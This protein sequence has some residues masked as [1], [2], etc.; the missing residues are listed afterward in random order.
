[1]T[2]TD[3]HEAQQFGASADNSLEDV[4]K[5]LRRLQEPPVESPVETPEKEEDY[6]T[7]SELEADFLDGDS[8]SGDENVPDDADPDSAAADSPAPDSPAPDGETRESTIRG[9][10]LELNERL[11]RLANRAEAGD[12]EARAELETIFDEHPRLWTALGDFGAL[13]EQQLID[14]V[15]QGNALVAAAARRHMKQMK[16]GL[17]GPDPSM[18]EQLA[19]QR[20][21]LCWLMALA[22]D[23]LG[24]GSDGPRQVQVEKKFEQA[25]KNFKLVRQI[26]ERHRR[27]RKSSRAA[28][29]T[30]AGAVRPP[31]AARGGGS[32]NDFMTERDDRL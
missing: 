25:I 12:E 3:T 23:R 24:G 13:T 2:K 6:E 18:L 9:K 17:V 27:M 5:R 30:E 28:S 20:M 11:A 19:A 15:S 4:L 26:E 29:K 7:L 14:L 10:R 1:M 16:E 31:D 21:A 32:A 22:L 8:V